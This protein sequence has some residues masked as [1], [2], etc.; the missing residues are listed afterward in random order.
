MIARAQ[1]NNE[2]LRNRTDE[3]IRICAPA[4][5]STTSVNQ[6]LNAVPTATDG[7]LRINAALVSAYLTRHAP[8][9]FEHRR[10][11][12]LWLENVRF[13]TAKERRDHG[14]DILVHMGHLD[15]PITQEAHKVLG[16]K[17]QLEQEPAFAFTEGPNEPLAKAM[18][19]SFKVKK[20]TYAEKEIIDIIIRRISPN[21]D[22]NLRIAACLLTAHHGK[23]KP[24]INYYNWHP[25]TLWLR[26]I[27]KLPQAQQIKQAHHALACL[28]G[29]QSLAVGHARKILKGAKKALFVGPIFTPRP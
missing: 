21:P 14:A 1:S 26:N 16:V 18:D 15:I 23:N 6:V 9:N 17:P 12:D 8:Q 27:R 10:A 19:A 13:C 25:S 3:A 5:E 11:A 7:R 28:K 2:R 20:G 29:S 4:P 22:P 24:E